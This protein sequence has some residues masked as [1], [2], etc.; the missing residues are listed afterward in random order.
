MRLRNAAV[1]GVSMLA[2]VGVL[3]RAEPQAGQSTMGGITKA[4]A[5]LTPT[6]GHKASGTITFTKQA[7]GVKVEGRIEGLSPGEH[8]FHVHEFGD[9]SDTVE[10]KSTGGHFNPGKALHAGPMAKS[11]HVGD[12]GNIKADGSGVAVIDMVDKQMTFSGQNSIIGRGLIVHQ[13]ADDMK[14]Q[15]TGD[16]GGRVAQAVIG[17]GKSQ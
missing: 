6:K 1:V 13:K 8:G 16:A 3:A 17:V 10:A 14:T 12:L 5:V 11:R 15:P 2:A 4:I 9:V 7:D